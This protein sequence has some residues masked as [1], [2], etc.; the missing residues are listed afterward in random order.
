M[1]LRGWILLPGLLLAGCGGSGNPAAVAGSFWEAVREGDHE[2]MAALSSPADRERLER[3]W[4]TAPASVQLGEVL[5]SNGRAAVETE[6]S[7]EGHPEVR[8]RLDTHL[9]NVDGDWKVDLARTRRELAGAWIELGV[10]QARQAVEEGMAELAEGLEEGLRGLGGA[11]E[12]LEAGMQTLDEALE[13]GREALDR[14]LE[15]L[16]EPRGESGVTP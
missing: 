4:K 10:E 2:R 12:E 15:V 7:Y 9:I 13:R 16:R 1:S 6:L 3:F 14:A 5:R 8:L 11:G